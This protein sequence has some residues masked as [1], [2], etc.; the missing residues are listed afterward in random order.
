MRFYC[1]CN[2]V[3]INFGGGD[4]KNPWG[5]NKILQAIFRG[6]HKISGVCNGEGITKS[7]FIWMLNY[8]LHIGGWLQTHVQVVLS[9]LIT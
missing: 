4:S 3:T 8:V 5:D 9:M 2:R 1:N 7:N 6:D